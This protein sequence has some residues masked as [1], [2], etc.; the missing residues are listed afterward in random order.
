MPKQAAPFSTAGMLSSLLGLDVWGE[1][2]E[3]LGQSCGCQTRYYCC[4]VDVEVG[5][6]GFAF[7][8]KF[9]LSCGNPHE[10]VARCQSAGVLYQLMCYGIEVYKLGACLYSYISGRVEVCSVGVDQYG[11]FVIVFHIIVAVFFVTLGIGGGGVAHGLVLSN[12]RGAP[13][14]RGVGRSWAG[15]G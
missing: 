13:G 9:I 1:V 3:V 8:A 7:G 5:I 11:A 15:C 4:T 10:E 12:R 6:V 14:R 2:G